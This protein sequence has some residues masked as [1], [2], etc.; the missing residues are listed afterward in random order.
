MKPINNAICTSLYKLNIP[1]PIINIIINYNKP[2]KPNIND[3]NLS[4]QLKIFINTLN[5]DIIDN[6][7]F[8][9]NEKKQ[10]SSQ[11]NDNK[12]NI[13]PVASSITKLLLTHNGNWNKKN[14]SEY[15]YYIHN[16]EPKTL[17]IKEKNFE[18]KINP[19]AF[20]KQDIFIIDLDN[21]V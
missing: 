6:E 16:I 10:N 5:L 11:T 17:I 7:T 21:N 12:T 8:I 14:T 9:E 3:F 1:D 15:D 2:F 19:A 20:H 13:M 4:N 18:I